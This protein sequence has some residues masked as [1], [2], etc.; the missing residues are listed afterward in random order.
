[1]GSLLHDGMLSIDFVTEL[2]MFYI[3]E[4]QGG[5]WCT[6]NNTTETCSERKMTSYGS[7]KLM[8][9]ITFDGIFSNQQ[10]QNPG[11]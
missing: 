8:E 9:A 7:S 6:S 2:L 1:M 10:T 3:D 5:A 4:T 11:K